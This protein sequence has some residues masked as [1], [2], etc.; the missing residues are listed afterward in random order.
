MIFFQYYDYNDIWD[1]IIVNQLLPYY[2]IN[3]QIWLIN[4][5]ILVIKKHIV[6]Y[7]NELQLWINILIK[8]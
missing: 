5:S 7:V 1:L 8:F 3:Y 4:R 2:N 6:F